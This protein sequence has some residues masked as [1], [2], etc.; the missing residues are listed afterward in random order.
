[1]AGRQGLAGR[2][3]VEV[4]VDLAV[5][6]GGIGTRAPHQP[7][8]AFL[9]VVLD[10]VDQH[11]FG[12]ADLAGESGF[13]DA[14]LH[15]HEAG[16]TFLAHLVGQRVWQL[17]GAGTVHRRVGEAADTIELGLLQ[18]VQQV[19]EFFLGLA[20]KAGDEGGADGEIGADL[21]PG[22]DALDVALAAG[23]ALHQ[24]EDARVGVLEGHVQ[25]RQDQALGHQRQH[26]VDTW[27]RVDVVQPDPG[28]VLA[29]Q[30]S[31]F[32]AQFQHPG[33]DRAAADEVGAIA[34]VDAI[35]A[36]VLRDHQQFLDAGLEQVLGLAHHL[37]DRPAVE[38]AAQAG[39][40]AEGA[41][42]VA[43]L[44]NLQVGIVARRELD[45]AR[46]HQVAERVMRF[47][48]VLVHCLHHFFERVRTGDGQHAGV[49]VAHQVAARPALPGAGAQTAG[50]DDLAV[51]GQRLA[52]GIERFGDRIVDEAAGVDD[53][54]VGPLVLRGNAV[55]FGTQLG[56]DAFGIDQGLGAAQRDEADAGRV[57]GDGAGRPAD[58]LAGRR[59]RGL[60][61]GTGDL[62]SD[63]DG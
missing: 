11:G 7:P 43:A 37:A 30:L 50:D 9:G 59:G 32:A 47:G 40:D 34:Q 19:P 6:L 13:A 29:R 10:G 46:G 42:M 18:E 28:T 5:D 41:A 60:A 21:A 20:G 39:D 17:V 38:I 61:A 55:A 53:D 22:L 23:R 25:I 49:D 1:M 27:V 52:D 3:L 4:D 16:G 35:G 58:R 54:Q 31:Q 15:L 26:L 14:L 33:P 2:G 63:H 8:P 36:G 51:F 44:G 12:V 48:Q 56:D 62:G 57:A 45:A 24:L